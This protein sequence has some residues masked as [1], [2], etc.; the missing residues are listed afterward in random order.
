MVEAESSVTSVDYT[1]AGAGSSYFTGVTGTVSV[2]LQGAGNVYIDSAS[3]KPF[4]LPSVC[5]PTSQP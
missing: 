3:G 2:T 1:S 4:A 5:T